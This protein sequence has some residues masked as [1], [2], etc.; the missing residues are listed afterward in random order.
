MSFKQIMNRSRYTILKIDIIFL[1]DTYCAD[2]H[3]FIHPNPKQ[4]L[5]IKDYLSRYM[6]ILIDLISC[7]NNFSPY[8]LF[9]NISSY[10]LYRTL[11]Y[12]RG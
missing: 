5:F 8:D 11:G 6:F 3:K 12:N 10:S 4:K 7:K 1:Q 9:A 2:L